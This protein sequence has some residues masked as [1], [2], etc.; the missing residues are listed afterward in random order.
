MAEEKI[1]G[2]VLYSVVVII[3]NEQNKILMFLRKGEEWDQGW[4]PIKGAIHVGET[5]EQAVLREVKEEA[6]LDNIKIVGKLP[7]F[8]RG[9]RPWKNGKLKINARVFVCK[10]VGGE[11]KLGEPEHIDYKW[12]DVEEAKEKIWLT[13]KYRKNI[14]EDAYKFIL[15]TS[16]FALS[17]NSR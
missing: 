7:N 9:E 16:S 2:G 17:P 14:V 8:Y 10:Y 6:G 4:E 11:I 13:Q 12:M 3:F 15:S 5:E 1:I